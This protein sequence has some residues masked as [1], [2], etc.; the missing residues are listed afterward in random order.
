MMKWLLRTSNLAKALLAA[1]ILAPLATARANDLTINYYTIAESDKDANNLACCF[2]IGDEV[3][4]GLGAYG[5][6]ILNSAANGGSGLPTDLLADGEIT[7]WSPALNNGGPGATS[8]VTYTGTATVA[9]PFSVPKNFF[10]PNGTGSSDYD[11]F[12]AATLTGTLYAPEAET[13]S[14]NIGS[15]DMAFA[16]LDG[17]VV[18]DDGGVHGSDSVGCTSGTISAGNHSIEVFFVD[19][20]NSQSGLTFG[21]NTEDVTTDPSVTPE[22]GTMT[23]LGSGLLALAGCVR[24]KM[25]A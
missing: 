11:G 2:V 13:I 24:R 23:L 12:Q 22:P 14:F 19:I 17:Q 6:P 8:D 9:L 20:N 21:V 15:D 5:F 16:Y 7:Y 3:Q 18:C 1:V 25:R 10:P 4:N